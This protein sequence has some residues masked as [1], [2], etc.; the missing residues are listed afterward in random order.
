MNYSKEH[1]KKLLRYFSF[2]GFFI[3]LL[4]VAV[5]LLFSFFL[6]W[7]MAVILSLAFSLFLTGAVHED[8]LADCFDAFW[9]GMSPEKREVIL[10]DSRVGVFGV[11]SLFFVMILKVEAIS[12]LG[13]EA[14]RLVIVGHVLSR[15]FSITPLIFYSYGGQKE[16][17]SRNASLLSWKNFFINIFV[18]SIVVYWGLSSRE[19]LLSLVLLPCLF[20]LCYLINKKMGYL[21]GDCFG[22]IQQTIE[23]TF[24][25]LMGF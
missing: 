17:K 22:M 11:L 18:L 13:N 25:I 23:V 16:S 6:S 24:Y 7:K 8:G 3:G 15:V 19:I 20:F 10:K 14:L 9:G 2:V 5:L 1:E 4:Q 12:L 21:R